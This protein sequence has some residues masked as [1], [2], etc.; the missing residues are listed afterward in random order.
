MVDSRH[1]PLEPDLQLLEWLE[2]HGKEK[3]MVLTKIDKLPRSMLL[4]S[5]KRTSEVLNLDSDSFVLF[6]AKTGEGKDK[7]LKWIEQMTKTR[8]G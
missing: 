3:L 2:F 6:S 8:L 7:I 4:S 5:V 1:G